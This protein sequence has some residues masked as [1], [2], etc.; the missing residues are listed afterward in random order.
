MNFSHL[1][2]IKR[3]GAIIMFTGALLG[4]T[5]LAVYDRNT[6]GKFT[7]L[8]LG[9]DSS[10]EVYT[11]APDTQLSRQ[12]RQHNISR[13]EVFTELDAIFG[14]GC[15]GRFLRES[16]PL[17]YGPN[18]LLLPVQEAVQKFRET[19]LKTFGFESILVTHWRGSNCGED[20]LNRQMSRKA[21]LLER[22]AEFNV[23][24]LWVEDFD[25]DDLNCELVNCFYPPAS[26]KQSDCHTFVMGTGELSLAIKHAAAYYFLL[27][28]GLKS[29]LVLEDDVIL[30]EAFA[31]KAKDE[32]I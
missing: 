24:S 23:S 3:R 22:L 32:E 21:K 30:T 9:G 17:A 15:V 25:A 2:A 11:T 14:K 4:T 27:R 7:A 1:R 12:N 16:N 19:N 31:K 6:L 26:R 13:T 10:S 28:H 18:A 20:C 5:I 29:I 8:L